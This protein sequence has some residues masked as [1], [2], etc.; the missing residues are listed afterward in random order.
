[1][2]QIGAADGQYFGEVHLHELR[3]TELRQQVFQRRPNQGLAR[4]SPVAAPGD[5]RVFFVGPQVVDLVDWNQ[6]QRLVYWLVRVL[7]KRR[8]L[9]TAA[10]SKI[11]E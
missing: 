3:G 9:V 1:M 10:R 8:N 4:P 11:R 6:A 7:V 5:E 2:V